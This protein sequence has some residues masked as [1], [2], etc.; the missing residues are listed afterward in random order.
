MDS[1]DGGVS[2]GC[3]SIA[4]VDDGGCGSVSGTMP[5]VAFWWT[6]MIHT[7][8]LLD[9]PYMSAAVMGFDAAG[10]V[11]GA[12]TEAGVW[13]TVAAGTMGSVGRAVSSGCVDIAV[14]DGAGATVGSTCVSSVTGFCLVEVSGKDPESAVLPGE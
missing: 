3:E 10:A 6:T 2:S 1:V 4:V 9:E 12:V 11:D 8:L 7:W 5:S 13:S 14:I